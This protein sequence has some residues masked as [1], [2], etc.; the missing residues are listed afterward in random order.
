MKI[1]DTVK[2]YNSFAVACALITPAYMLLFEALLG[3]SRRT[4]LAIMALLIFGCIVMALILIRKIKSEKNILW[5]VASF[6]LLYILSFN[7]MKQIH[8]SIIQFGFYFLLPAYLMQ[9]DID[10]EKILRYE[11]L[12]SLPMVL[13][14]ESLLEITNWGLQQADMYNV[15]AMVPFVLASFSHFLHY[16]KN[17]LL[18]VKIG[19][20]LNIYYAVRISINAVRGF[21]IAIICYIVLEILYYLKIKNTAKNYKVIIALLGILFV[22]CVLNFS[23]IVEESVWLLQKIVGGEWGFLTK[24]ERLIERGDL[25]NGRIG[26]WKNAILCFSESPIWGHGVAGFQVWNNLYTYPHNF[27][28]QLLTDCGLLFGAF[29]IYVAIK[30]LYTVIEAPIEKHTHIFA[31]F[32][33]ASSF[34]PCLLSGDMWKS[35]ALWMTLFFYCKFFMKG[36]SYGEY[37]EKLHI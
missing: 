34:P 2:S 28:L 23:S 1:L 26:I 24:M 32:L 16:R 8:Y 35:C 37:K 18:L 21:L 36:K 27:I 33:T 15:Y 6:S 30:G 22:F 9:Q 7:N 3:I 14:L 31:V 19:Y 5:I 11:V 4:G 17:S 10:F 25:S 20:I 29:P 13:R 12:L